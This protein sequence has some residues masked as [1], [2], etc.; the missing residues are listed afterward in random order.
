MRLVSNTDSS[1]NCVC[2]EFGIATEILEKSAVWG[3]HSQL[4]I[5]KFLSCTEETDLVL[6]QHEATSHSLMVVN[7]I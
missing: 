4:N 7:H 5:G 3:A 1:L 6:S 2:I